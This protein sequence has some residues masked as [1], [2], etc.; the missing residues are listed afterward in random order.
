MIELTGKTILITGATNGIGKV[1][2][3]ELAK[4][5]PTI[6]LVGRN[7]AKVE[8]TVRE[9]KE[10]S[11]NP[12]V[13]GLV[14]DLFPMAEVRRLANEFRKK[15]PQ[16]HVL[17]NNAGAVFADRQHTIDGYERTFALNHLSYFLLTNLLLD[18]LKANAPARIVNVSS[19][20]HQGAALDFDDLQNEQHYGAGGMR[21]YGQSKLDNLLFTYELARRLAGSGVTVNALHPGVVAT[22][23]GENNGGGI[24]FGMKIFHLFALTPQQ[25]ADTIVYLAS[26]TEVEGITGKYWEKRKQIASSPASYDEA[27]QKRLWEV[28]AQMTGLTEAVR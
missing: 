8:Q 19:G 21:A 7:P 27:T 17:I 20:A 5:G 10:Q 13:D 3:L 12:L 6:V 4:Q 18:M 28:S 11:G 23:F 1:A 22:G 9:I 26:S 15:Y 24:R 14:A 16:L 2:A 25:G